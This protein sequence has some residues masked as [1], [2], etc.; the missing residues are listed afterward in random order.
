M[1]FNGDSLPDL[2]V[3]DHAGFV[4][5]YRAVEPGSTYPSLTAVGPIR[6]DDEHLDV[7]ACSAPFV[8]DWD[9]DGLLDLVVG[10]VMKEL[11]LFRNRGISPPYPLFTDYEPILCQGEPISLGRTIPWV[12][13]ATGDGKKDL[14]L[15]ITVDIYSGGRV[16]FLENEGTNQDPVF[17]GMDTLRYLGGDSIIVT[18]LSPYPLLFDWNSD[19]ILDLVLGDSD[20]K[21]R[22]FE[23]TAR[24]G[25]QPF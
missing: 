16:L 24:G 14:M 22:I 12:G 13:D 19:G 7:G 2:L 10:S 25:S 5:Y 20:G 8:V 15:G 17:N 23:G 3:G 11:R 1:D 4:E 18:Q 21:I 6:C 9:E